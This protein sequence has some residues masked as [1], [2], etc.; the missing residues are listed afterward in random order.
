[1][2]ESDFVA[3]YRVSTDRQG[4]SGLGLE[5]QR[6]AV[7]QYLDGGSWDL[8]EEFVEVESG[9]RDRRPE[10]DK[11]LA[12]C[13]RHKATLVVARLDRL[14]RNATFLLKLRDGKVR[15]RCAD[16]P[17]ADEF[18]IGIMA[19]VAEREGRMISLRTK[20][21]LAAA[22]ARGVKLGW[23]DPRRRPKMEVA[24]HKGG[25]VVAAEAD[26]YAE[27]VRP[28]IDSIQATGI[29]TLQ[30]IADALNRRGIR[31]ARGGQWHPT[32]VRNVLM[33]AK[34]DQAA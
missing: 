12:T 21:A 25:Q 27:N 31:T 14:A 26:Q 10:L 33:R 8:I 3:Y 19:L 11:A 1:M 4:R 18:V 23:K 32:S 15:I 34:Q 9:K 20:D 22:R 17:E 29:K 24:Q 16:M 28:I 7:E 2:A 6:R 13:R 5:A 30:G